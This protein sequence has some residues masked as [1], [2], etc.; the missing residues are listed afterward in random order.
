MPNDPKSSFRQ[1]NNREHIV[2]I[3]R[4]SLAVLGAVAVVSTTTLATPPAGVVSN[5]ILAQGATVIPLKEK[6]TVGDNWSV[7][8]EDKGQSDFYFQDLV[9]GPGGRTGWHSHPGLLLITVKEGSVDF[10]D[11]DCVKRTYGA[12]QSFSE[13]AEPHNAL[14]S[15]SG[16]AHLLIAYIVKKGEPRRIESAQPKCGEAFGLL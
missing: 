1:P 16:N 15:G 3:A 7:N 14:N 6:I 12:G 8:L 10:Y 11:K 13:S 2:R 5:V 4:R 9:V